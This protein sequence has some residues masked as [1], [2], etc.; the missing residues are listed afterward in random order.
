MPSRLRARPIRLPALSL[1]LLLTQASVATAGDVIQWKDSQ[2]RT[3][4]SE[5]PPDGTKGRN[6]GI[7]A[8]VPGSPPVAARKAPECQTVQCQYERMRRYRLEDDAAHRS[9]RVARSREQAARGASPRGMSFDVFARLERGMSEGEVMDRAGP[10][11]HES[12]DGALGAKTWSYPPTATDPFTTKV[13]LRGGQV[14]EID[15][16]RRL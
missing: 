7:A 1:A 11:D 15:R 6:T 12:F 16:I 2:G 9:E 13:I 4:Y 5:S 10:P 3:H 14:F 8:Q